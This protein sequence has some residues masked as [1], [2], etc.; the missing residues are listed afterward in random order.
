MPAAPAAC[1]ARPAARR[2]GLGGACSTARS[3]RASTASTGSSKA[4]VAEIAAG[5]HQEL[6]AGTRARLDRRD[7]RRARRLRVRG[8]QAPTVAQLRLLILTPRRAAS[9]WAGGWW[10]SA[11]PSPAATGY[12]KMV[13]WTQAHLAAARAI[14]QSRGFVM[15]ASEPHDGYGG[16]TWSA[17][18]GSS[19]SEPEPPAAGRCR[20]RRAGRRRHRGV[21]L[22]RGRGA[23]AH[24]GDAALRRRLPVPAAVRLARL[25]AAVAC[26][27]QP[28]AARP[29]A[30]CWRWRRWASASSAC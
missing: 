10:T 5:Y 27:S 22:R 11:S 7:R 18:P 9:A 28:L 20:R 30:T 19:S 26:R 4:L 29:A 25:R 2:H 23:A 21:A 6:R 8:A 14:Y 16:A 17:R 15:T 1:A 24:A 13:L 12:R 3:T